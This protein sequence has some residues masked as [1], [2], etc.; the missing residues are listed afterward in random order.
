MRKSEIII[1]DQANCEENASAVIMKK[2][3]FQEKADLA[4][5][6][7]SDFYEMHES[8]RVH[9][10]DMEFYDTTYNCI[11]ILPS[12]FAK[13]AKDFHTAVN[14]LFCGIVE[15]TNRQSGGIGILDFDGD[16]SRYIKDEDDNTLRQEM[17]ELCH[18]LNLPIRKGCEKAYVTLNFGL[19]VSRNGRRLAVALL[20]AYKS[21][22]FTF[23]NLVFTVKSGVNRNEKDVNHPIFCKAAETTAVCM[24]PTYLNLDADFNSDMALGKFGIMG[25]RSRI[26]ANR[27]SD[28]GSLHRGNIAAASINLVQLALESKNSMKRYLTLLDAAMENAK[29][30]L[31]HRFD[32]LVTN[33]R[34]SHLKTDNLYLDANSGDNAPMLRNGTL[35]IG[36]I[37]LWDSFCILHNYR[38]LYCE[39]ESKSLNIPPEILLEFK[40]EGLLIIRHM[41]EK[42]DGFSEETNKNFSLLASSGEGISGFFPSKDKAKYGPS[43][44]IGSTEYYTNSFHVPVNANLSCFEKIDIEA[45]FHA[46]CNGGHISYVELSEAPKGNS[47]AICELVTYA[48]EKNIGYFGINYPM[49]VCRGCGHKGTFDTCPC[50]GSSDIMRLRRVSGYLSEEN[51]MTSGKRSELRNRF[52]NKGRALF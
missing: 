29:E 19:S 32:T 18:A 22:I 21:G 37:G 12:D 26:A 24:N 47:E 40:E 44:M 35:A 31:V 4:Q 36:F 43:S 49:D 39:N 46:L 25:C 50:C 30:Q 27:F 48:C 7:P 2:G 13:D 5:I 17:T 28:S 11:G 42:T 20:D 1:R 8:G 51:T 3:A 41:R 45:P 16:L 23:P 33:G 38:S 9:I 6:I 10:H 14:R 15:L 34:L 52:A